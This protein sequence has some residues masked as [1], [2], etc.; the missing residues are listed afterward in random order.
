[1]GREARIKQLELFMKEDPGD[2]FVKFALAIE[3]LE[4]NPSKSRE[5]FEELLSKHP[6]Y[7][8]TYYHAASLYAELGENDLA[9][10][11]YE[12]GIKKAEEL[13]ELHALKELKS[14]YQNFQID[15]E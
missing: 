4:L 14:A 11:I 3:H 12:Q 5:L 10:Q 8:G 15:L 2:P 7:V 6:D 13:K 9:T 1:M